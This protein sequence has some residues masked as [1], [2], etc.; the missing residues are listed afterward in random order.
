MGRGLEE[1]TILEAKESCIYLLATKVRCH[2]N[3]V[4]ANSLYLYLAQT[5]QVRVRFVELISPTIR[6]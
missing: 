3:A 5:M 1:C 6:F 4:V 2:M